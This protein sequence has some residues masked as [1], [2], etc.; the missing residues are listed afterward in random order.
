MGEWTGLAVNL[1]TKSSR[2]RSVKIINNYGT[3]HT[4]INSASDWDISDPL[5]V[6]LIAT[7]M[8]KERFNNLDTENVT[9]YKA[10]EFY[11]ISSNELESLR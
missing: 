3:E 2:D 1:H 5:S 8:I 6:P 9:F 11:T 7:E 4:M 10:Y